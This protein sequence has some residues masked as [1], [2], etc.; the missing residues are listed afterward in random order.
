MQLLGVYMP[1]ALPRCQWPLRCSA[2][3]DR[4][5]SLIR[6][7]YGQWPVVNLRVWPHEPD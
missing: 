6:R 2:L 3:L 4:L 5:G 1:A 7:S